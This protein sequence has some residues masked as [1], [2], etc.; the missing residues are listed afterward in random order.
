[1]TPDLTLPGAT[2]ISTCIIAGGILIAAQIFAVEVPFASYVM[3]A[4]AIFIVLGAGMLVL[5]CRSRGANPS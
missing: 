3:V 4:L 2:L 1:M 5:S